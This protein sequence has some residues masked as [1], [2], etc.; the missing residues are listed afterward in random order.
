MTRRDEIVR[1]VASYLE[2]QF[3]NATISSAS[4]GLTRNE[5][6]TISEAGIT[7]H[8]EVTD[9]WFDEDEDV[10]P[11]REAIRSWALADEIRKLDPNAILRIATTGLERVS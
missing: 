7:R 10:I 3:P 8:V 11:L 2:E 6:F 1:E 9:R 5:V 4:D